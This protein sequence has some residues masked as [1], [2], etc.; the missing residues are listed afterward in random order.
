MT[1]LRTGIAELFLPIQFDKSA[2]MKRNE[3]PGKAS[4]NL[5]GGLD[6]VT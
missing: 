1:G 5:K 3:F 4:N 2:K 6:R